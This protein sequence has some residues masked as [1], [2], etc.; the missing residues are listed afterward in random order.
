MEKKVD[1]LSFKIRKKYYIDLG[2]GRQRMKRTSFFILIFISALSTV[3]IA[4]EDKEKEVPVG[5]EL[6][7]IKDNYKLLIPKGA[8]IRKEGAVFIIEN[9]DEY[10]ARRFHDI[11]G[12]IVKIEAK[13]E[14]LK[15]EIEQLKNNLIKPQEVESF[16]ENK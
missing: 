1:I 14:G 5:M 9:I 2:L 8:K 11:E 4:A 13:E 15:K 16:S 10:V 7:L 6:V 12:R 3:P